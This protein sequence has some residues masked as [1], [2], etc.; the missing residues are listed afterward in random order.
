[1]ELLQTAPTVLIVVLLVTMVV[2]LVG[3]GHLLWM[4]KKS[5]KK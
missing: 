1:M 5:G 4:W 3:F 2:T